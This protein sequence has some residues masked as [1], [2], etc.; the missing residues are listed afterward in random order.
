MACF[1]EA[2]AFLPGKTLSDII[3]Y[4][5]VRAASMR[6]RHFCRGRPARCTGMLAADLETLGLED[7]AELLEAVAGFMPAG[8][9]TG[10]GISK[11]Q[12]A[13]SVSR[14]TGD[15]GGQPS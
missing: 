9:G 4:P 5:I 7:G 12:P 10:P 14:P 1:N 11:S 8:L 2:P 6:P 15:A 3:G 13:P